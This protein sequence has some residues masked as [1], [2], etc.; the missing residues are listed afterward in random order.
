MKLVVVKPKGLDLL[1]IGL[2]RMLEFSVKKL[3]HSSR[4]SDN[5]CRH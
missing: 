4:A 5:G 2:I 3:W 1:A